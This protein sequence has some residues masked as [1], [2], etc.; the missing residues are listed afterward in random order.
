MTKF[1]ACLWAGFQEFFLQA[2][3]SRSD[4]RQKSTIADRMYKGGDVCNESEKFERLKKLPYIDF[5][6]SRGWW[7][8]RNLV[9]TD[10][11]RWRSFHLKRNTCASIRDK[12]HWKKLRTPPLK[13]LQSRKSPLCQ[14]RGSVALSSK[15]N[16]FPSGVVG[17]FTQRDVE[18]HQKDG[19]GIYNE[20]WKEEAQW[21][22]NA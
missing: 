15:Q 12:M 1:H 19:K 14:W 16:N 5:F 11:L 7:T 6:L 20:F 4:T 2:E 9:S 18:S 13:W 8:V 21:K 3:Q 22:Q 10:F 17:W